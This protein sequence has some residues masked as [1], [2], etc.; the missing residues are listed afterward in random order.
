MLTGDAISLGLG[1]NDQ[2]VV[3]GQSIGA[4]S[5]AFIWE[6]RKLT[7]LNTLVPAGS[8][9]LLFANDINDRGEIVGQALDPTSG[10]FFAF[11]AVPDQGG[12]RE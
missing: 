11:V 10:V 7:D 3:V 1:I 2:G 6:N 4:T 5:R 12:G 9:Q 8:P